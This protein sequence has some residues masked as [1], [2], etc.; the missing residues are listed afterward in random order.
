[1]DWKELVIITDWG[2]NGVP[3]ALDFNRIEKNILVM[4]ELCS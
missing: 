2:A 1:M 3:T 4:C